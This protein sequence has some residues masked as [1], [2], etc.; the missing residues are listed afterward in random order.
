MWWKDLYLNGASTFVAERFSDEDR[1][2]SGYLR[3]DVVV[4]LKRQSLANIKDYLT[5][6]FNQRRAEPR[7]DLLTK[8]L[9]VR[10]AES[11]PLTDDELLRICFNLYL[12]GLDTVTGVL[13]LVIRD[14]AEHADHRRQ[15]IDVMDDPVTLASAVE[16]LLRYQ[17]IVPMPRRVTKDCTFQ[18][19]QLR[20]NDI[21]S[22][23]TPS[24]GRDR[25]RF[26]NPDELQFDRNPN[27]HLAF[28]LGRHRCLGIHL[29]RRELAIGLQELHRRIPDYAIKPGARPV[30]NTGGMRGLFS[31]PIVLGSAAPL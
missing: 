24:A 13:G 27:P 4:R 8:L 3:E 26:D 22:L 2:P 25:C 7:D 11:R 1:E 23:H 21:V 10:Y 6:L 20:E 9:A 30:V 5:D 17:S 15:F 28:G 18:G 19:V 31:L 12:G 14:F 16:E 29:A